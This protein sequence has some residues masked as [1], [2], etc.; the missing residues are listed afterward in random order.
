MCVQME[1]RK[2]IE[3]EIYYLTSEE[4]GRSSPM[5]SGYRGQFYYDGMDCDAPQYFPEAQ[6]VNPGETVKAYIVFLSPELHYK[7][8]YEGMEF[9][10]REGART[11]G[12]GEVTKIIDLEESAKKYASNT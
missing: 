3:A 11:V 10:I 4:G 5:Y 8:V 12:R 2:D 6:E 1:I 9:L 7:K